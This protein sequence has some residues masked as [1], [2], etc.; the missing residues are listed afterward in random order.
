[1]QLLV[2]F[3]PKEILNLAPEWENLAK[4]REGA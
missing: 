4:Q 1:M 2:G 3:F